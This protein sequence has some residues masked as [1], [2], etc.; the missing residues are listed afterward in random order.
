MSKSNLGNNSK[1][2]AYHGAV[3]NC[4]IW[5][6]GICLLCCSCSVPNV[7]AWP[8]SHV[9]KG[10]YFVYCT[11]CNKLQQV[12]KT[13]LTGWF[14]RHLAPGRDVFRCPRIGPFSLQCY[15]VY[16]AGSAVR[17]FNEK[18]EKSMKARP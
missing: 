12:K 17:L 15:A 10:R 16:A 5:E 6:D 11:S 4:E 8:E 2:E 9:K 14:Y 7:V 13:S 3:E 18:L 1:R